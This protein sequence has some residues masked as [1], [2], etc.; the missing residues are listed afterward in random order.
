MNWRPEAILE[1]ITAGPRGPLLAKASP[2]IGVKSH[3]FGDYEL[4]EE[5]A[6][7]GMGHRL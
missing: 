4:L 7:G 1:K 3:Y 5:I 2:A 6:R